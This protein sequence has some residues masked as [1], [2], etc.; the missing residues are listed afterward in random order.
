MRLIPDLSRL[1]FAVSS[2][3]G[4]RRCI[5]LLSLGLTAACAL[6]PF[7]ILPSL[8][9]ALPC[10]FW[11]VNTARNSLAAGFDG[12]WF[13]LG[14]FFGGVHWISFAL[15]V[16][17]EKFLW[18]LPLALI[19]I[20][21]AL[22]CFIALAAAISHIA[23]AGYARLVAF[24]ASWCLLEWARAYLL[25]GFPWNPIAV[26]W[27]VEP[28]PLQWLSWIGTYGLGFVTLI[29]ATLPASLA[30]SKPMA[31]AAGPVSAIV[32]VGFIWIAGEIRLPNE[33]AAKI[34][35]IRLR[36]VQPNIQQH[37]KWKSELR[38]R[39]LNNLLELSRNFQS[40]GLTH[41]IWP[42][43]AAP[44]IISQDKLTRKK[45]SVVVPRN[46]FLFTGSLRTTPPSNG[47][48]RLWNSLHALDANGSIV[49]TY[50]KNHLVPFGEYVPFRSIFG[51]SKITKGRTDFT[52][53]LMP[54]NLTL[55]KLPSFLPLI[56]YEI[57]FPNVLFS[58]PRPGW[59][60]NITNDAWFG[61][62]TGPKQHFALSKMRAVEFGLPV[63]RA[64]NTG[65][66][67]MIDPWGRVVDSL[68][69]G[70]SG[71]IDVGLPQALPTTVYTGVGEHLVV[72]IVSCIL[73]LTSITR[74]RN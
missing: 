18:M 74:L 30:F 26:I 73:G 56:C 23:P 17:G 2:L 49:A 43:T 63:A 20:P 46:G 37:L 24:S 51:F 69:I 65:V 31:R 14:Y 61:N 66:S 70:K 25:T 19:L 32:L 40:D 35:N 12:W 5:L 7:Y 67:A 13:G 41:I 59:I 57:I 16:D 42:E 62:S 53:G 50:D 3:R 55:P 15:F 68:D 38:D 72:I 60:I 1:Q 44:F 45:I 27:T 29:I 28:A 8:W 71:Y 4:K 11:L 54:K 64:A 21:S 47:P 39:H 36:I 34:E 6:P 9:I 22:A 52:A 48:F 58:V 33:P 10:L